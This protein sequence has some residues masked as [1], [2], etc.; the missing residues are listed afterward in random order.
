[1]TG[2]VQNLTDG[3][4]DRPT[5]QSGVELLKIC[6]I[7][8][9][10]VNH[11]T[12]TLGTANPSIDYSD[13]ILLLGNASADV[14]T[15]ILNLL[16]QAGGLGNTI[17]FACSAWFLVGKTANVRKKAFYLLSTVWVISVIY[18]LVYL[19]F[20]PSCLT[21]RIILK[22]LLPT[23]FANNWYTTCYI[24]FLFIYP[25]INRLILSLDQK[26]H[27]RMV[28]FSSLLWIITNYFIADMFFPSTLLVWIAEYLLIAYLRMYCK[29]LTQNRAFGFVLL[30]IGILG[31]VLQ[32]IATNYAGLYIHYFSEKVLRWNTNSCPFYIMI[33]VGALIIA[34]QSR[35]QARLINYVS[36]LSLLIYLIHENLLFRTFT[37]PAMWQYLY[38]NY[39][40]SHV[41]LLDLV[42]SLALFLASVVISAV[43]KATIQKLVVKISDALYRQI[44]KGYA[45]LERKILKIH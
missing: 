43:Y 33:A 40:Y 35:L 17:F 2:E 28:L 7:F 29:H 19:A 31:Y 14:Q 13:Y 26:Q 34:G 11:V 44:S 23:C 27:L 37:R 38:A 4:T 20:Y 42:F 25:W 32:V 21:W 45:A 6:A 12:Q 30:A 24:I 1:M 22:E 8:L 16:R 15:V 9:I 10:V 3:R 41:V 18:L 5:R 36:G 39:G